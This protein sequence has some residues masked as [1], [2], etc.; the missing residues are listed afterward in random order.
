M[1]AKRLA[2]FKL[3]KALGSDQQLTSTVKVCTEQLNFRDHDHQESCKAV[4]AATF[5]SYKVLLHQCSL[6]CS[7]RSMRNLDL[8]ACDIA[9]S[10]RRRVPAHERA[11]M[12]RQNGRTFRCP[13]VDVAL[14]RVVQTKGEPQR[15]CNTYVSHCAVNTMQ[16]REVPVSHTC[17]TKID[18]HG[19]LRTPCGVLWIM[20]HQ[21]A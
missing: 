6:A 17:M 3:A 1:Y 5:A 4:A 8:R 10:L 12:A 18:K 7:T 11:C 9:A 15:K 16:R 2:G 19:C 20:S 14:G 21:S 13:Q